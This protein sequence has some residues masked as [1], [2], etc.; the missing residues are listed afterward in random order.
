MNQIPVEERRGGAQLIKPLLGKIKQKKGQWLSLFLYFTWFWGRKR[1]RGWRFSWSFGG[2][3]PGFWWTWSNF[4]WSSSSRRASWRTT[5]NGFAPARDI[6]INPADKRARFSW[7][8]FFRR[9]VR[10]YFPGGS[11]TAGIFF[12]GT[13][14]IVDWFFLNDFSFLG[15]GNSCSRFFSDPIWI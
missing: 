10:T 5:S 12:E 13:S 7:L 3:R 11:I 9:F 14:G 6:F 1:G 2:T 15:R 8:Y 4:F